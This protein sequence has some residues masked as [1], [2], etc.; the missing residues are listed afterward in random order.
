VQVYFRRFELDGTPLIASLHSELAVSDDLRWIDQ[1]VLDNIPAY[2][3]LKRWDKAKGKFVFQHINSRLAK[4]LRTTP[5]DAEGKSD[6]DY[7][8]D[9]FQIRSFYEADLLVLQPGRSNDPVVREESFSPRGATA[10][11]KL[12]TVKTAYQS[13]RRCGEEIETQ[14]LG[15]AFDVTAV[16]QILR[17]V[18]DESTDAVYIKD[19][20]RRYQLVNNA[21]RRLMGVAADVDL[22]NRTFEEVFHTT[23]QKLLDGSD[24]AVLIDTIRREDEGVLADGK[25]LQ[26]VRVPPPAKSLDLWL[27]TKKRVNGISGN[28]ILG[29]ARPLIRE[30]SALDTPFL[31]SAEFVPQAMG[32]KLYCPE[33]EMERQL[34]LVWANQTFLERHGA[35]RLDDVVG[36]SDFDFWD[37]DLAIEYRQKDLITLNVAMQLQKKCARG[38]KT[39]D[40]CYE[41]LKDRLDQAGCWE[42]RETQYY[43]KRKDECT[44]LQTTKWAQ[45][46]GGRWFIFVVYSDVTKAENERRTYHRM[47]AH[48]IRNGINPVAVARDCVEGMLRR[49]PK[50]HRN[51]RLTYILRLLLDTLERMDVALAHHMDMVNMRPRLQQ[52]ASQEFVKKLKRL[53]G[54]EQSVLRVDGVELEFQDIGRYDGLRVNLDVEIV[55][56]VVSEL[57]RNARSSIQRAQVNDKNLKD[58]SRAVPDW[59]LP[60]G[61][62]TP[63]IQV[64]LGITRGDLCLRISDNGDACRSRRARQELSTHFR[65]AER[66]AEQMLFSGKEAHLGMQFC[67]LVLRKHHG[68]LELTSTSRRTELVIRLPVLES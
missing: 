64:Q 48:T 53:V 52:V 24:P 16:T 21:F 55:L 31:A 11:R 61:R 4:D 54:R 5:A 66:R 62:Y 37:R 42:Y 65:S 8:D 40:E 49:Q 44:F 57:L 34:Q 33:L 39:F 6:E 47:T 56:M 68:R 41:E 23:S 1:S 17:T 36:K 38:G 7:F 50:A 32:I 45:M 51:P 15:V 27:T 26:R 25:E 29:T 28:Y 9:N 18:A 67:W 35:A 2:I 59:S 19:S 13:R 3:F 20:N 14:V 10:P 60:K 63:R 46:I 12:V 22:H 58:G 30:G 43:G